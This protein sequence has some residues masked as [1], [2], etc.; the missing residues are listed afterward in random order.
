MIAEQDGSLV[1]FH[2]LPAG[3]VATNFEVQEYG[4]R[5]VLTWWQGRVLQVGFGVGEDVI[6]DDSYRRVAMVRAGNGYH[7][8]LH[9]IRVTPQGTAWIDVFEPIRTSLAEVHGSSRAVLLDAVVQEIDV[10]TGL[11]M[12]EWH[13]LGHVALSESND[14]L[15]PASYPWDYIHVNSV[16]PGGEGGGT[17]PGEGASAPGVPGGAHWP[18]P[19]GQV[20]LSARNTWALY[21]VDIHTGAILWRLG[22]RRS[23]F[24]LGAG[25]RTYWQHDAEWRSGGLISV[26]DNGTDPPKEPQTR[27]VLLRPDL[28][29]HTVSL[30]RAF[31]NP[32]R[33]LLASSQGNVLALPGGRWLM[34]YGGL[35]DFTEYGPSGEVLLDGT[36]GREVQSFRTYLAPWSGQPG[37]PPALAAQRVGGGGVEVEASWN[38]ATDVASWQV[39]V[40]ARGAGAPGAGTPGAG[41]AP[42]A[43]T[44]VATVPRRGF[45]T[46]I[47]LSGAAAAGAR[48]AR[49]EIVVRALDSAGRTLATSLPA[50][51]S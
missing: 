27:G 51:P 6:Y 39:L 38:G 29:N 48:A 7:A 23:S 11:V 21:D 42:G 22:G 26:F 45:E 2:P 9:E 1:W 13:A 34:G 35:P 33:R 18:G 28:A 30:A 25:T 3:E 31:V 20:L 16:D 43:L 4:G 47:H 36:L 46:T 41:A 5:P 19:A 37:T 14:P 32:S 24:A 50:H 49:A 44:P 40:G 12:W 8:D 17:G 10:R 15:P